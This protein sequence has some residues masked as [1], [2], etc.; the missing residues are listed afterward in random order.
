MRVKRKRVDVNL[1]ELDRVLDHAR[2]APA[3][4]TGLRQA[5]R[6]CAA[7][8]GGHATT[9]TVYREDQCGAS[10]DRSANATE[11]RKAR[12]A[13][14]A[15]ELLLPRARRKLQVVPHPALH[16]GDHCP[17]CEKGE[18]VYPQKEPRT[19]VRALSVRRRWRPPRC[20]NWIVLRCNLCGEVFTAPEPEGVGPEKYDETT[21]A[22]IAL[23]KST[24]AACRFIACRKSWNIPS[25]SRTGYLSSAEM[26]DVIRIVPPAPADGDARFKADMAIFHAT[27]ALEGSA[28][29]KLAAIRRRCI[30]S[31]SFQGVLL[32]FGVN[33]DPRQRAENHGFDQQSQ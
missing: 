13:T 27:R 21:A 16:T 14:D 8:S 26:P 3:E 23:L 20:T 5:Q 15:T 32:H 24:A 19:L 28:R 7:R 18:K 30:Y 11:Q 33:A 31:R 2:E 6:R 1:E 25:R 12:R 17:G 22:M 4:R 9:T 10:A 29:W